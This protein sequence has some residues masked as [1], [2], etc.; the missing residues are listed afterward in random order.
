[1]TRRTL[2]WQ[3]IKYM[4][5]LLAFA[6][7]FILFRSLGGPEL[8]SN[9]VTAF[10]DVVVGETALRRQQGVRL[11]VTRL[12]DLQ[13]QQAQQLD[14]LVKHPN[15]GC[16]PQTDVCVIK[17]TTSRSGIDIAFTERLPA[18]L[19]GGT[20]WFGGFVDPTTGA[21]FDRLGRAY[22]EVRS[23]DE[24]LNLELGQ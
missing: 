20:P 23:N 14:G 19:K 24:R 5:V 3:A 6:F 17:S 22:K 13:R 11:W 8:A 2:L 1:M 9:H 21:V 18:Q 7:V 4:F 16:R 12:S 10:D 15:V